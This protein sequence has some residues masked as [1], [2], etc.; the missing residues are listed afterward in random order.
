MNAGARKRSKSRPRQVKCEPPGRGGRM[1]EPG[2]GGGDGGRTLTAPPGLFRFCPWLSGGPGGCARDKAGTK[3]M[4]PDAITKR[5]FISTSDL[6]PPVKNA[7]HLQQFRHPR[8]RVP[9]Q[10]TRLSLA[11]SIECQ[12]P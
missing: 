3:I 10:G 4:T 7:S 9:F 2:R 12:A 8:G 5:R 1:E 11:S 6:V